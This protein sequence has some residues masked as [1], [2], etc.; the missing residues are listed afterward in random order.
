MKDLMSHAKEIPANFSL[1]I[2]AINNVYFLYMA[3]DSVILLMDI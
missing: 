3:S 2:I 1:T